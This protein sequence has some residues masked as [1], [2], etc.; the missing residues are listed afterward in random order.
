M[1][2]IVRRSAGLLNVKIEPDAAALLAKSS[3]GTPRVVNRLLRRMRDFA[4]FA[5]SGG[6]KKNVVIPLAVVR[7]GLARLEIDSLGLEKQDRDILK[8]IIERYR[9]GPVGAE[10]LAI[11]IG[12]SV[13]TLED[14]YEP[15]MI[16]AGLLQRSPRGRMV[17]S[18]A[19][20][21]LGL[22]PL[23]AGNGENSLFG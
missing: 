11:S 6:A 22:A 10:T 18:L 3:R 2:A 12:E 21:H 20:G 15:F 1:E 19:Y 16:Q 9:G 7:D 17:T 23:N 14:Y 5:V 8:I 13:E 4:Q